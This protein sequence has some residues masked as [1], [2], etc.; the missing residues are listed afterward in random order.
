[1]IFAVFEVSVIACA[2]NKL[3]NSCSAHLF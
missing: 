3:I 2:V 1:M